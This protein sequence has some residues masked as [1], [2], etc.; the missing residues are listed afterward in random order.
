MEEAAL[1]K[2]I[3]ATLG[4]AFLA[5][6]SLANTGNAAT[7]L[8]F[9]QFN[10]N[11][12]ITETVAGGVTT[13]TSGVGPTPLPIQVSLTNVGGV[14]FPAGSQL[15]FE[16]FTLTSNSVAAPGATTL[17]GFS[18]VIQFSLTPGGVSVLT[19]TVS[20]GILNVTGQA[21][22]FSTGNTVFTGYTP[23]TSQIA[24]QVGGPPS[25]GGTAL[26]FSNITTGS[27]ATGFSAQNSGT[28]SAAVPEPASV[29]SGGIA[30]LAGVGL[31]GLRRIRPSKA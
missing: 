4:L 30:V 21:G 19:A 24:Q 6:F 1:R 7:I 27:I 8:Q 11:D 25:F 18:G 31:V 12:V 17:D 13:L 20:N 5:A 2:L 16:T 10:P 22:T 29:V 3:S 26:G 9:G 28:F 14:T 15:A 23:I